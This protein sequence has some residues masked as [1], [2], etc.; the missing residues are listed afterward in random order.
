M[1]VQ[2]LNEGIWARTWLLLDEESGEAVLIDPVM[3][4]V[5]R[6]IATLGEYE[7]KYAIATHTHADHITG[8]FELSE[9]TNADYVMWENTACTGVTK[10]VDESDVLTIGSLELKFHHVPG[11]T[12]DS[13]LVEV[14]NFLF[15]GDFLFTGEGGVGRDD[16]PSGR[17]GEHWDSL[18]VLERFPNDYLV[19]TGHDPPGMEM[20]TLGWARE[21]NPV[22]KISSFEEYCQW[23]SDRC[24][25]LG[26]VSKIRVALPSNLL[27]QGP[28]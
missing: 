8:C 2:Q 25:I 1:Q 6:D 15:T 23:Q 14:G 12:S 20:Q 9:L 22:L 4:F 17:L 13:M 18:R 5:S 16:L 24:E 19:C 26:P 11:H 10:L 21:N 28:D 3:E 7:L 27:A